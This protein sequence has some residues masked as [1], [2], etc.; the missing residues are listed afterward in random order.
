MHKYKAPLCLPVNYELM[1]EFRSKVLAEED[2]RIKNVIEM[3]TCKVIQYIIE[4]PKEKEK[5]IL[6][7]GFMTFIKNPKFQ[8]YYLD[9][10]NFQLIAEK[11]LQ[12][13]PIQSN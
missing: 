2:C 3:I 9:S 12:E 8:K 4:C 5:M 1:D 7:W 10:K 13:H 6:D 11:Y